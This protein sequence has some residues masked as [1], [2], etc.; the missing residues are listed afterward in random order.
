[1]RDAGTDDLAGIRFS[2]GEGEIVKTPEEM[3]KALVTA[4]KSPHKVTTTKSSHAK[5]IVK[6]VFQKMR[7][8][9][10]THNK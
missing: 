5:N 1:V 6:D 10:K 8:N 3:N 2:R 9:I 4:I 7:N